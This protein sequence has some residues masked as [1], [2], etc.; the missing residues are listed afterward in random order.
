MLVRGMGGYGTATRI[1]DTAT[2]TI[3]SLAAGEVRLSGVVEA[4]EVTL[5]SLLQ[6]T[7]CVHYK[8]TVE[9]SERS[10]MEGDLSEERAVG[11]RV[12]DA[13]GTIRIFP[14]GARID[15]PLRFDDHTG[16]L[17]DEPMGLALRV[18]DVFRGAE[19]DQTAA[20]E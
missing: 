4:A 8:A 17:G 19:D 15:S 6:S 9:T 5:V 16:T 3:T 12:R 11:F 1:G 18:G 7:T 14:R 13:S 10:S 20:A 2:S